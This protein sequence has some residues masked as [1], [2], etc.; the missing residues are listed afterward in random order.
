MMRKVAHSFYNLTDGYY[1][2]A[3]SVMAT[4]DAGYNTIPF[5][6]VLNALIDSFNFSMQSITGSP[7]L[8]R[9]SAK[10]KRYDDA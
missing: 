10:S 9:Y 3:R 4:S 7:R 5:L 6:S 8:I 2:N 1:K